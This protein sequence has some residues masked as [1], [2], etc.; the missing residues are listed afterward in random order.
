MLLVRFQAVF[1]QLKKQL[2]TNDAKICYYG[3]KLSSLIRSCL[4]VREGSIRTISPL[5]STA[6]VSRPGKPPAYS[7]HKACVDDRLEE[8]FLEPAD[9]V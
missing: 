7:D 2:R 6:P 3:F 4:K 8:I 9:D 1:N 5:A